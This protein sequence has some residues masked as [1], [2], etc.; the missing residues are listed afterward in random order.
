MIT[1]APFHRPSLAPS[2]QSELDKAAGA[3]LEREEAIEAALQG[4][5]DRAQYELDVLVETEDREKAMREKLEVK[6]QVGRV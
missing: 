3:E 1:Q 4:E 2:A 5:F 6:K